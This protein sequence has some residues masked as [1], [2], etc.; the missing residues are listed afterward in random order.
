MT[1]VKEWKDGSG[2]EE[3]TYDQ[4]RELVS[5]C[6]KEEAVDDILSH[7]QDVN[8]RFSWLIITED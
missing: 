5:C 6:Y 3:L 7:A 2:S 1:Y 8:C 4:A